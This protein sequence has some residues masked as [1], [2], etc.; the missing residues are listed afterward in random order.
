MRAQHPPCPWDAGACAYAAQSGQ[1]EVLQWMRENAGEMWN[2][3]DVRAHAVGPRRHEV[4]T[5]LDGLNVP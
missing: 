3:D 1:L 2:E 5:W 4:L